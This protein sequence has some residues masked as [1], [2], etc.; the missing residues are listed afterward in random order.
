MLSS[1]CSLSQD[2]WHQRRSKLH[3]STVSRL[4]KSY[5]LIST[6]DFA[7]TVTYMTALI[8]GYFSSK[9]QRPAKC[10]LGNIIWGLLSNSYH[11]RRDEWSKKLCRDSI[12]DMPQSQRWDV[13]PAP[14]KTKPLSAADGASMLEWPETKY[15]KG[16]VGEQKLVLKHSKQRCNNALAGE[17]M[18]GEQS[19]KLWNAR[20]QTVEAANH[21]TYTERCTM[22]SQDFSC[23]IGRTSS[24]TKGET[25]QSCH[26]IPSRETK[27]GT[28]RRFIDS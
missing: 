12:P 24:Q 19:G 9:L 6:S 4:W 13:L 2:S 3:S 20:P 26:S 16:N 18:T 7:A 10:T 14:T 15:A 27:R 21:C 1:G 28:N 8:S 22:C 11:G 23:P 17:Q 5:L 25:K